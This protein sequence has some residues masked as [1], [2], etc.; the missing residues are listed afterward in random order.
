MWLLVVKF[1]ED[2]AMNNPLEVEL[3]T[4]IKALPQLLPNQGKYVLIGGGQIAGIYDTYD[5]AISIGYE[6]FGIK[7]FL[8]KQIMASEQVQYFTRDVLSA[9]PT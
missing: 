7:P 4:Y 6:K 5:D 1:E 8:V 9:C 2:L 3:E